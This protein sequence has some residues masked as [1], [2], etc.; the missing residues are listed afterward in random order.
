ML[1]ERDTGNWYASPH[2][3]S[4]DEINEHFM[5]HCLMK[6]Y[7]VPVKAV[8]NDAVFFANVSLSESLRDKGV[9]SGFQAYSEERR[10][11]QGPWAW[12][13]A[14]VAWTVPISS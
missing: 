14:L 12:L 8:T 9:M 10:S 1:I 11:L 13:V 3:L 2:T 7:L 4:N 5:K 6:A